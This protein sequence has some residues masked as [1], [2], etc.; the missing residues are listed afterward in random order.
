MKGGQ[1]QEEASLT[2]GTLTSLTHRGLEVGGGVMELEGGVTAS[3]IINKNW[4]CN[5]DCYLL[6]IKQ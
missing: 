6:F 1:G 5:N 3:I 4:F 2:P